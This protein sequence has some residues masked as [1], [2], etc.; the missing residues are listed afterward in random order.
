MDIAI[1][2]L[3]QWW[4]PYDLGFS[5]VDRVSAVCSELGYKVSLHEVSAL[6][7]ESKLVPLFQDLAETARSV[8]IFIPP[9]YNRLGKCH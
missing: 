9:G 3:S 4:N 1:V 6:E 5:L 8:I 7:E 2:R